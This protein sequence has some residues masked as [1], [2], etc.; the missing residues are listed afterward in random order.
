MLYALKTYWWVLGPVVLPPGPAE[1][2][3]TGTLAGGRGWGFK[4]TLRFLW[5]FTVLTVLVGLVESAQTMDVPAKTSMLSATAKERFIFP[6]SP[7]GLALFQNGC[8]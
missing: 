8:I 4:A 6:T 7:N 5:C 1:A 3:S 2:P